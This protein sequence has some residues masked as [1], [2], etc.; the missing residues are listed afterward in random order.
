[1]Q[2]NEFT[3]VLPTLNEGKNIAE[4]ISNLKKR[5]SGVSVIVADD[6]SKD[7]TVE[8]AKRMNKLY[9][10]VKVIERKKLRRDKGLTASVIDGIK[11]CRTKYAVV[12]DAD[13]QHPYQVVGKIAGRLYDG[14]K[15]TVGIRAEVEDWPFYRKFVSKT[16]ILVGYAVLF[17]R[18][19]QSCGDIFSGFFGVERDFFLEVYSKNKGR[20]I[21]RGFKVLFDLLKC[22]RRNSVQA[23]DVPY[24][25][26]NRKF[27]ESK[28][29]AGQVLDL[30]R[31]FV[32]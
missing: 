5:Y 11:E 6:G 31:S 22:I 21:G 23:S 8:E 18:R 12:M 17:V 2:Y 27:G 15:I 28:A 4:L 7:N 16:L 32:S 3:V 10:N 14:D 20:F 9:G 26:R 29:G 25:F 24:V 30:V 13:L 19:S 1:M